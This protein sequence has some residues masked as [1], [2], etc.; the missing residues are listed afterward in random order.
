MYATNK[1]KKFQKYFA[2]FQ[3]G[4]IFASNLNLN[5]NC[6]YRTKNRTDKIKIIK[7]MLKHEFEDLY[8]LKVGENEFEVINALYMLNNDENKQ[9]FVA[10]YKKM[11]KDALMSEFI[12]LTKR[13]NEYENNLRERIQILETVLYEVAV[14]ADLNHNGSIR[15]KVRNVLGRFKVINYLW[16]NNV[17]LQDDDID[18]LMFMADKGQ[19]NP[20]NPS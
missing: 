14:D 4:F 13:S 20:S 16:K 10:R 5:L 9:E 17:P 18:T 1:P 12:A 7:Y 11:S 6:K 2:S 3:K 15:Q 8:G 19:D